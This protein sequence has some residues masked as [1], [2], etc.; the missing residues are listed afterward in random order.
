MNIF[1][2]LPNG[3]AE[4]KKGEL[5]NRILYLSPKEAY[6]MKT[7]SIGFIWRSRLF[8]FLKP[9]RTQIVSV[10]V[11]DGTPLSPL[12]KN[13]ISDNPVDEYDLRDY[14]NEFFLETQLDVEKNKKTTER[15]RLDKLLF[16]LIACAVAVFLVIAVGKNFT[17]IT[18]GLSGQGGA[19]NLFSQAPI[20]KE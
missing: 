11:G 7:N 13:Y 14:E 12:S 5:R 1:R 6:G 10:R 9:K 18:D 3:S 20:N 16:V 19:T 15:T 8:G 17:S 4:I 2:F